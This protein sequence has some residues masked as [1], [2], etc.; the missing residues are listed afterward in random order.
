MKFG[1]L[2][3]LDSVDFRFQ[4]ITD[5]TIKLINSADTKGRVKFYLGAPVWSDKNY[6]GTLYPLKTKQKDFLATYAS[7]FNSIEV[8]S[9]RYGTPKS[10]VI[11]KWM[12]AVPND[13]KFSLK[14]PQV[15]TH[16]KNINDDQ[17]RFRLDQFILALDQLGKKSGISYAVMANYF[18]SNQ[19]NELEKFV[20][21]LPKEMQ[22]AIEFRD[23]SWFQD[24]I[25]D[26]WQSLFKENNIIPVITDTP[27]RR[28]AA[29]FRL[30]N[31]QL[32]VR[33]VGDFS[34]PSDLNRIDQWVERI[35]VLIDFGIDNIWFYVHQPGENRERV[36]LF[37][38]SFIKKMNNC[39]NIKLPLLTNYKMN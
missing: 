25:K 29:H 2:D 11:N 30:I 21:N 27:G 28:D 37:F 9:T 20:S 17:S 3:N 8:N 15:I 31:N 1:Q 26:E 22:F 23:E 32:F 35:K 24:A 5:T 13:F 34:H 33:Y 36:V 18:K 7:Q 14:V 38:N 16:R 12:N 6:L 4:H 39:L 19:M 10:E